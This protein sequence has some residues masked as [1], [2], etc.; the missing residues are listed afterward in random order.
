MDM[1]PDPYEC[2]LYKL[3]AKSK[4]S[5]IGVRIKSWQQLQLDSILQSESNIQNV[6]DLDTSFPC[7]KS[8]VVVR[9]RTSGR[10]GLGPQSIYLV[11]HVF[12]VISTHGFIQSSNSENENAQKS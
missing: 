11:L 8:D 3:S 9:W 4:N 2:R 6:L 7:S 5:P 10:L 12:H 1:S